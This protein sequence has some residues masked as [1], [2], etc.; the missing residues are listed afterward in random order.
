MNSMWLSIVWDDIVFTK[1]DLD[2]SESTVFAYIVRLFDLLMLES[3]VTLK[4]EG[5]LCWAATCT[6]VVTMMCMLASFTKYAEKKSLHCLL[7]HPLRLEDVL[8]LTLH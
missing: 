6:F 1:E 7:F 5:R 2:R 8:L 3:L 4:Q